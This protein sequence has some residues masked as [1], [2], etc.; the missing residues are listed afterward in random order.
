MKMEH[1]VTRRRRRHG[2]ARCWSSPG[3]AVVLDQPLAVVDP[4]WWTP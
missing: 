4:Y 1:V 3:D 2:Q